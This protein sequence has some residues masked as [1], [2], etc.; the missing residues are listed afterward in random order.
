MTEDRELDNWR[1]Q[2]SS[3]AGA[4]S[5][6]QRQ[7]RLRI[8]RQNLRFVLGNLL[9][10]VAFAGMLIFAMT[11]RQQS[12]SLGSGW[13]TAICVLVVVSVANRLWILR[14]TWRSQAHTTRAHMELWRRR[15]QAR[16]RLLQI[17]LYVSCGW[18]VCCAALMAANWTTIKVDVRA[19]PNE[20]LCG[21]VGC[22][23]MQPVILL[24]AA[25]LRRR[26][27]AELREVEQ[28]LGEMND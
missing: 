23:L 9:T 22:V 7:V 12:E 11:M 21:L 24:G 13:M 25:M 5:D 4:P 20:W 28:I 10:A 26:K 19:H 6:F 17:A 16:I 15:A 2:W 3:I 27:L 14:G 1:E 8:K 18:I